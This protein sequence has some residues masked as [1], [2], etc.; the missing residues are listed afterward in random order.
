MDKAGDA[1]TPGSSGGSGSATKVFIVL[2]VSFESQALKF[3]TVISNAKTKCIVKFIYSSIF[4][5]VKF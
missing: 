5:F 2:H 3:A 1:A 4:G